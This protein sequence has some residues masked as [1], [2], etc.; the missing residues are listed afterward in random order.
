MSPITAAASPPIPKAQNVQ[1]WVRKWLVSNAKFWP[2]NPVKKL[3]GRKTVG[4][5]RE[6]RVHGPRKKIAVGVDQVADADEVVVEVSEVPLV[7]G[8]HAG[9]TAHPRQQAG[10]HVPLRR[11]DLAQRYQSALHVEHLAQLIFGGQLQDGVFDLVDAIVEL[12]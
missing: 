11:H 3:S 6:V 4:D 2:K 8:G 1:L 12:R 5:G 7:L 9:Q 10:D